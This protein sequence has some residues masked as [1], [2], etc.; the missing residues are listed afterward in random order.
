LQQNKEGGISF[1]WIG[2]P[3]PHRRGVFF[4]AALECCLMLPN[5][6]QGTIMAGGLIGMMMI[7]AGC[8]IGAGRMTVGDF[9]LVNTYL[10]QLYTPLNFPGMLGMVYR[11]LKQS[12]TDIEQ[13]TALFAARPEIANRPG[14][15][16][17][18]VGRDAKPPLPL[19]ELSQLRKAELGRL[20]RCRA[21]A[22]C[23]SSRITMASRGKEGVARPKSRIRRYSLILVDATPSP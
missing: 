15:P 7:L 20:C 3:A 19:N 8:G 17:L 9:G 21:S 6:G 13:M 4:A 18:V 16:V 10:L 11:N 22:R 12:P 1:P 23:C 14:A 5:V 2:I